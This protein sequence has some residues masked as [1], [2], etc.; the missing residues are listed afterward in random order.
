MNH[1]WF[2][3]KPVMPR[4]ERRLQAA[5]TKATLAAGIDRSKEKKPILTQS[6]LFNIHSA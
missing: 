2:F 5:V 4:N 6:L 1:A 3:H